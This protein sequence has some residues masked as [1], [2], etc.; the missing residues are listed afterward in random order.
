MLELDLS[1]PLPSTRTIEQIEGEIIVLRDQVAHNS[2]LIGRKLIEAKALVLGGRWQE[3]V[4]TNIQFSYRTAARLMQVAEKFSDVS[5]LAG[6]ETTKVYALLALPDDQVEDFVAEHDLAGM[7]SREVEAAV[8]AQKAAESRAEQ[9]ALDLEDAK[10]KAKAEK[11]EAVKAAVKEGENKLRDA[12]KEKRAA[13]DKAREAERNLKELQEFDADMEASS[14]ESEELKAA[15]EKVRQ[16]EEDLEKVKMEGS[17][18]IPDDAAAELERLRKL[19]KTAPNAEVIRL[20]EGYERLAREFDRVM[21]LLG[22]LAAADE[23]ASHKFA[24]AIR[25]SLGVMTKAIDGMTGEG[26]S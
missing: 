15:R 12:V 16:L 13:L 2:I 11:E 7:T 23:A 8:R 3:W 9:L 20:R 5:A 4:E 18:K 17:G 24:A 10:A 22:E 25:K 6:V 1:V 19:E 21:A 14:E 26:V